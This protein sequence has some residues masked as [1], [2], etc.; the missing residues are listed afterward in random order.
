MTQDEYCINNFL[1]IAD[2]MPEVDLLSRI[3][4]LYSSA[5]DFGIKPDSDVAAHEF[6]SLP[7]V[8]HRSL[9]API[10]AQYVVFLHNCCTVLQSPVFIDQCSLMAF[11]CLLK[12]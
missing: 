4:S 12:I 8:M 11:V 2:N 6:L 1:I 5:T 3:E 9:I 10:K 7:A